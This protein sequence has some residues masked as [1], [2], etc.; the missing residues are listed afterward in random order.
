KNRQRR[1]RTYFSDE[2]LDRLETVFNENPYPDIVQREALGL[3]CGV[4]EARIQ[5]WFQNRRSRN[6]R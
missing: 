2:S 6:R 4:T 3:E 1:N 5:V